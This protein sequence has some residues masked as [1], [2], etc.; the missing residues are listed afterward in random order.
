MAVTGADNCITPAPYQPTEEEM[1]RISAVHHR[2][3]G[4]F[5]PAPPGYQSR[6]LIVDDVPYAYYWQ[7][8]QETYV[9]HPQAWGR[10]VFNRADEESFKSKVY[11]L[12]ERVGFVLPNGGLA[13][14]FPEHYPLG[15]FDGK[16]IHYSAFTQ[17]QILAG[18]ARLDQ[19]MGTPE[20]KDLLGRVKDGIFFPHEQGGVNLGV[21]QLELPLFRANPEIIL[22]GWLYALLHI[23]DYAHLQKDESVARY[24]ERSLQFFVDNHDAWYDQNLHLSRYSDTSPYTA[25]L[26]VEDPEQQFSLVYKS[27]TPEL[28][29]YEIPVSLDEKDELSAF[30]ARITS[31][32]GKKLTMRLTCSGLFETH[33][34][35]TRPFSATLSTGTYD[36][37][38]S[39]PGKGGTNV[40]FVSSAVGKV[41]AAQIAHPD[42]IC[43]YPTNFAKSNNKNYYHIQHI[44]AMLY[45][46]NAPSYAN[47]GLN[48]KLT[49]IAADWHKNTRRFSE[50]SIS[51]FESEQRVLSGINAGKVLQQFTK[52]SDLLAKANLSPLNEA[53]NEPS[54]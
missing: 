20:S 49:A 22:N 9:F 5:A 30:D 38:R 48:E 54:P 36:T 19:V 31:R 25:V 43:G 8:K 44:V 24:V 42:L 27:K 33:L 23:N 15:R 53:S 51:A 34:V 47:P 39:A 11:A 7:L 32:R 46:A 37:K 1:K 14:Y 21:A 2:E 13:F 3:D 16:D 35:S 40:A 6:I 12:T 41:N 10:F 28:G 4:K 18:Y 26:T 29:N 50:K 45:L 17:G 52:A